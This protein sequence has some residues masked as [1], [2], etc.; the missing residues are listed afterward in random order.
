LTTSAEPDRQRPGS[1]LGFRGAALPIAAAV[2][3]LTLAWSA[4]ACM[5]GRWDLSVWPWNRAWY[6]F[7]YSDNYLHKI[8]AVGETD[9]GGQI[10]IDPARWFRYP[11]AFDTCRADEVPRQ[12]P[13]LRALALH[14]ARRHNE[15]SPPDSQ[16]V[17]V[18]LVDVAWPAEAGRR[19]RFADSPP[20]RRRTWKLVDRVSCSEGERKP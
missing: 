1:Q 6:M 11:V 20:S 4:A 7:S 10:E 2:A 9:R 18:S 12:Y 16:V 14:L 15:E 19:V 5:A 8:L 13:V 3:G 17:R